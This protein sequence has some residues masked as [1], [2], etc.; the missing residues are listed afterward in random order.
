MEGSAAT[1]QLWGC[2]LAF[3]VFFAGIVIRKYTF[4]GDNSPPLGKQLLLGVPMSLIIV[5]PLLLSFLEFAPTT[6]HV[7]TER[8]IHILMTYGV[9]MEHGMFL[10]ER[11]TRFIVKAKQTPVPVVP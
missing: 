3:A 6:Q 1:Q 11:A 5:C 10:M 9:I 7:S 4:P 8:I 2:V